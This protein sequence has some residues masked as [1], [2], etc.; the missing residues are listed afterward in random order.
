VTHHVPQAEADWLLPGGVGGAEMTDAAMIKHA[1]TS[2]SV[3]VISP[4][5]WESALSY[6]RIVITGTDF[7]SD[8]AMLALAERKP[9]VWVHHQQQQSAARQQLFIL[10]DPFVTMSQAHSDVEAAWSG[11]VSE[12]CHGHIDCD[13]EPSDKIPA[14]LWSARNHPQKGLLAARLWSRSMDLPL[15][16][17]TGVPRS[18]V[19]S[20]MA[21][22]EWFVFL[23]QGFDSCP[24]TLIEA[25]YAGCKIHT[26]SKA[27]RRDPGPLDE[28]MAAQAPKFWGWL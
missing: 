4:E 22:H 26:N 13:V 8:A 5:D 16:E 23:P 19:L 7:L 21:E 1:P 3:D 12:W 27:G 14:A 6:D 18:Q 24:R 17:L 25:E 28:V 20:A 2:V 15:T 11:V 9:I 10:A